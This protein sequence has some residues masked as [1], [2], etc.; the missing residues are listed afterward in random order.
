MI[1]R[2]W[3][4]EK[5]NIKQEQ[6]ST[7]EYLTPDGGPLLPL[8]S[9]IRILFI[10]HGSR[11]SQERS[12]K[13]SSLPITD[14]VTSGPFQKDKLCLSAT[15]LHTFANMTDD[16]PDFMLES[17]NSMKNR[18]MKETI[19][20]LAGQD[21]TILLETVKRI[22][23]M[24]PASSNN[25]THFLCIIEQLLISHSHLFVQYKSLLVRC[26]PWT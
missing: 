20:S 3:D 5:E 21:D 24:R 18:K 19:L 17:Q 23:S 15:L 9:L 8:L 22:I 12:R 2:V 10:P 1:F 6:D 13:V 4:N 11:A 14:D 16:H 26:N 25:H 7:I